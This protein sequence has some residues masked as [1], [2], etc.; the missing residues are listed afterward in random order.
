MLRLTRDLQPRKKASNRELHSIGGVDGRRAARDRACVNPPKPKAPDGDTPKR[1]PAAA[2]NNARHSFGRYGEDAAA[3][4]LRRRGYEILARNVRT[5]F[6]EL[7]LVAL[8]GE[9][10]VFVEVKARRSAGGLEAVD[11]RKQR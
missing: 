4:Y 2:G 3:E 8:D 10:V 6:G 11:P 7:D 9:T 5:S 1:K